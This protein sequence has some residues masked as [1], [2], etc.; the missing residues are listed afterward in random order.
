MPWTNALPPDTRVIGSPNPPADVD[1]LVDAVT[2]M[3]AALNVQNPVF[4]TC[5]PTGSADST[6]AFQACMTAA[7]ATGAE[8]V[9]PPGTYNLNTGGL[10]ITGP[11]KIRGLGAVLS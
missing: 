8:M 10:Q 7:V 4:G 3:G 5:D 1:G 9:I 2:A 6:A 11:L